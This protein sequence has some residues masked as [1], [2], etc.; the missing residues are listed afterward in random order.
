MAIK[1]PWP[2]KMKTMTRREVLAIAPGLLL[3]NCSS[4][5]SP[6]PAAKPPEPVTGLHALYQMYTF[7]RTWAQDLKVIRLSSIDIPEVKAVPGKGAAWQAQFASEALGKT[8]TYTFSVYEKSVTLR[9]G[10]FADSPTS[11]PPDIRSFVI[12]DAATDSDKAWEISRDHGHKYADEH[13]DMPISYILEGDR[14]SG[15]PVWR[16]IW[17][18]SASSSSFSVLVDAHTGKY[19][20]T[21]S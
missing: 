19:L 1:L 2:T 9:Q 16:V 13:P 3:L 20:R 12:A 17:G 15:A 21:Q 7:S 4:A 18:L 11:L 8:R 6:K 5:T 10:I 14:Q